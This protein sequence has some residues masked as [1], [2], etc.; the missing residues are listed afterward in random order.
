MRRRIGILSGLLIAIAMWVPVPDSAAQ[1][2]KVP[3]EPVLRALLRLEQQVPPQERKYF[4]GTLSNWLAFA[5]ALLDKP[6][7]GPDDDGSKPPFRF[8]TAQSGIRSAV[9]P[10]SLLP[11]SSGF[12]AADDGNVQVSNPGL[13]LQFSRLTGFTQSTSSSAWCGH[14][15]VTGFL[16]STASLITEVV[17]LVNNPN[18]FSVSNTI[19]GAAFSTNDGRSFTDL[20]FLNPGPTTNTTTGMFGNPVVACANPDKF[21]YVTSPFVTFIN[22]PVTFVGQLFNGVGLSISSDGGRHWAAPTAVISKDVFNLEDQAWLAIDPHDPNRLYITYTNLD[23]DGFFVDT[24]ATSRCPHSIRHAV[25]LVTSGDGGSTWSLPSVVT[26]SCD[27]LD[28]NGFLQPGPVQFGPQIAVGPVGD[29]LVSYIVFAADGSTRLNF[30]RSENHGTSFAAEV[31]VADVVATGDGGN[32]QGIFSNP[33]LPTLG[34]DP[35]LRGGHEVLYVAW[36]DGRDNPQ[37]DV[38]ASAGVYNFGDILMVKSAD[39]GATWSAPKAVSPT[40]GDFTGIGRDQFQ[41]GLAVNRDGDL[42]VCYYDRRNDP[43]NNAVDHYCSISHNGGRSFHDIRQ[44]ASSWVPV[45]GTDFAL[46]TGYLGLYDTIA[47]HR[48]A[49]DDERFFSGFQVIKQAIPS[50]HGRSFRRED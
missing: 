25:E 10:S 9:A 20:G 45:H 33:P 14:N 7:A 21:Y 5:H 2:V 23:L 40:P 4:S 36:S 27:P 26:E 28:S 42:A 12:D 35:V 29:V 46:G 44:T 49:N 34:V 30:R 6:T 32:L 17:P 37:P 24:L 15:V 43:Q 48:G 16:S 19:V 22:D 47:V 39:G 38:L 11:Q 50:V 31:K 13:D 1:Q 41:P 3:Q 8:S 18:L